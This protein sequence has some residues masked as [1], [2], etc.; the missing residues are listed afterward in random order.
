MKKG[1]GHGREH[2]QGELII[3]LDLED[4]YAK[5]G[6]GLSSYLGEILMVRGVQKRSWCSWRV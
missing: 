4:M 1:L 3:Y 6:Y 5:Y 2:F